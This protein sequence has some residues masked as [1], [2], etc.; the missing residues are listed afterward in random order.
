M[1]MM[2]QSELFDP[3]P[4][5]ESNTSWVMFSV[6]KRSD[7]SVTC[8][9]TSEDVLTVSLNVRC[10]MPVF[11]SRSNATKTGLWSSSVKLPT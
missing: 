7:C 10:I 8:S 3:V 6:S 2:G 9:T 11:I 1:V 5:K 4:D